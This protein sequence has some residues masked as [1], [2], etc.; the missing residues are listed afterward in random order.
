MACCWYVALLYRTLYT[1]YYICVFSSILFLFLFSKERDVPC[2]SLLSYFTIV[3]MILSSL[4]SDPYVKIELVN[5]TSN[6]GDDVVDCVLTKK[7][8]KV[9]IHKPPFQEKTLMNIQMY[10]KL[11]NSLYSF[12][13][14]VLLYICNL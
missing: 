4:F 14:S 10:M 9:T 12:Y 1:L 13:G 6:G 11:N 8:K 7:K 2:R 3:D 5:I